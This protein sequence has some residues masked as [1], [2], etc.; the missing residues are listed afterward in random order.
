MLEVPTA[1][2][3]LSAAQ[4][5]VVEF[6]TQNA[7]GKSYE[8]PNR[9]I[10]DLDPGKG[11]EWSQIQEAAM[12]MK[13]FLDQLE[14][15]SFLKTSGG[16]GLHLVVPLKPSYGWEEVKG[17]SQ[18]IVQHIA[19]TIPDR[20]SAKSGPAN[21]EGKIYIDYLR[22]GRGATTACAWSARTRPGLGISVPVAWEELPELKG[23]D[24]WRVSTVHTRLDTG[25]GPWAGYNQ[26]A[27]ELTQAMKALGFNPKG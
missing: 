25:N 14:L 12:I 1:E 13:A 24:H 11:I 20:F 27:V 15:P 6:H 10:F 17:F 8:K 4:W 5:N 18:A 23:G 7:V 3:L 26:S 19:T 16:K 22:N 9:M 2:G 21:R